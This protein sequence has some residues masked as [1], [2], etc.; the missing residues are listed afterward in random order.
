[1]TDRITLMAAGELRT[2]LEATARGDLPAAAAA[3][4]SI[5]PTSW[6]AIEHRLTVLGGSLPELL[7]TVRDGGA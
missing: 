4:M 1:M 3:L 2:A 7:A 6:Q 5:D